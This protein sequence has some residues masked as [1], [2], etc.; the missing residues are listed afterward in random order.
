MSF[1]LIPFAGLLSMDRLTAFNFVF[2]RPLVVSAIIGSLGGNLSWCILG[3]LFFELLG[4]LDLPVG[5]R[6]SSDDTFGAFAYSVLAVAVPLQSVTYALTAVVICFVVMFPVTWTTLFLRHING[7]LYKHYR[8][9]G[10]ENFEGWLIFCGQIMAFMRGV[11]FYTLGTAVCAGLYLAVIRFIPQSV[12]S[13]TVIIPLTILCGYFSGFF[14]A[15]FLL[16]I[17][18]FACGGIFSWL[19]F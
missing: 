7:V 9:S 15:G 5:T 11:I 17:M 16:K 6:I 8:K 2:S 12:P 1:M 18:L 4:L 13:F 14:H 10:A 19:I 3:G